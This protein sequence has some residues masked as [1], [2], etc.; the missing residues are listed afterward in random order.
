MDQRGKKV[1]GKRIREIGS[2]MAPGLRPASAVGQRDHSDC[3]GRQFDSMMNWRYCSRPGL[4]V[5]RSGQTGQT[6]NLL[7][8]A[9]VGSNPTAP[10][11]A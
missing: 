1:A 5:Y 2:R 8:H 7:A 6:V 9:F 11:H 10:I 3:A 4:G